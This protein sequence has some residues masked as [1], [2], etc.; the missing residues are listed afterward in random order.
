MDVSS[1]YTNIPQEEGTNIVFIYTKSSTTIAHRSRRT[2]SGK[3]LASS[4]KKILFNSM[5]RTSCHLLQ[6]GKTPK[7]HACEAKYKF[8]GDNATRPQKPH[9]EFA[10]VCLH[11]PFTFPILGASH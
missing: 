11:I 9:E 2:T 5:G 1:L 10:Q 6:K 8:G 7:R 3:Y 4:Q